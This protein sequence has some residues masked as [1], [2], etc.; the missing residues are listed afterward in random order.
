MDTV[1]E[2]HTNPL[3]ENVP[4]TTYGLFNTK[5]TS[6]TVTRTTTEGTC[7]MVET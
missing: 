4:H 7:K 2:L 3:L 1:R 5:G 6:A